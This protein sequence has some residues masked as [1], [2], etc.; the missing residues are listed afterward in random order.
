M[1]KLFVL[2]ALVLLPLFASA[3]DATNLLTP[4]GTFC[5]IRQADQPIDGVD[6]DATTYLMLTTRRG[7]V[8]RT[9]P[10]PAT[11]TEGVHS[12]PAMAYDTESG[13]LYIFWLRYTKMFES[14]LLFAALD[15]K[16]TWSE[17]TA[18]GQQYDYRENFKIAVTRK[19]VDE[20]AR[21]LPG[22][23]VHATWWETDTHSGHESAKYA[24]LAL[25]NGRVAEVN[26][27]D[28]DQFVPEADGGEKESLSKDEIAILR[29]PVLTM[30]ERQESVLL[31]FG[32]IETASLHR[33][34]VYPVKPPV[35]NGRIRIPVGRGEGGVP[36]PK[37]GKAA[38]N[39]VAAIS[40][41]ERMA[42]YTREGDKLHYVLLRDGQ[43]SE[44]RAIALDEQV[45]APAAVEAIRRLVNEH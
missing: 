43:W 8:T 1:K 21:L 33:V 7:D 45:S 23:T 40:G 17:A 12:N 6:I 38:S 30:T 27:L 26:Y 18:F 44:S 2:L 28:L 9:A 37:F 36:A 13:M 31:T 25:E 15:S 10:V 34:R 41:D 16:G 22:I 3:Q 5:M 20:K 4:D 24:I 29:H 32:A 11:L 42:Y 19:I 35:T 39:S 14:E